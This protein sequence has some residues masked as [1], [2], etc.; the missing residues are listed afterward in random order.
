MVIFCFPQRLLRFKI[1]LNIVLDLD[2]MRDLILVST[3]FIVQKREKSTRKCLSTA[4][5]ATLS[6]GLP[7]V[8]EKNTLWNGINYAVRTENDSLLSKD[9]STLQWKI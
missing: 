4:A 7:S 9:R 8:K 1:H 5:I 2:E 6:T 3:N